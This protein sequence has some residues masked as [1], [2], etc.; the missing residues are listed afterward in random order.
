M[1]SVRIQSMIK[2]DGENMP[3]ISLDEH[4]IKYVLIFLK[5]WFFRS[6]T[7]AKWYNRSE[8]YRVV[9]H[10][11][12]RREE[13]KR[14]GG[15]NDFGEV[16]GE[17]GIRFGTGM[18]WVW[19]QLIYARCQ[20][21]FAGDRVHVHFFLSNGCMFTWEG[22][23]DQSLSGLIVNS[24]CPWQRYRMKEQPKDNLMLGLA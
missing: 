14:Q 18:E 13:L 15:G 7:W 9:H 10:R 20:R 6:V 4:F 8:I 11:W 17:N 21:L 22:G 1:H 2:L 12:E 24:A 5:A 19:Y 23:R 16:R 3:L